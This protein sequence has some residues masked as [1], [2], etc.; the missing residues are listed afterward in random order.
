VVVFHAH[1]GA[2]E[3][4]SVYRAE[5]HMM[6]VVIVSARYSIA[7][8]KEILFP[9]LRDLIYQH[10]LLA[11]NVFT[12]TA[13]KP[14]LRKIDQFD[15]NDIVLFKEHQDLSQFVNNLFDSPRTVIYNDI[16]PAWRLYVLGEHEL[17]FAF[18]HG[19]FD[20]SSGATFHQELL[21]KLQ[22]HCK[23]SDSG[24]IVTCSPDPLPFALEKLTSVKPS[25]LWL[26]KAL[27]DEYWGDHHSSWTGGPP[28]RPFTSK[29]VFFEVAADDV[30]IMLSTA[31]RIG[32]SLTA[33]LYAVHMQAV[34]EHCPAEFLDRDL[35]FT[36]P[37]NA[38][39]YFD[40]HHKFGNYVFS[41][42]HWLRDYRGD[43]QKHH[44]V[45]KW[46]ID[47][48]A[49]LEH[50]LI[51]KQSAY[52]IGALRYVDV[53]AYLLKSVQQSRRAL[54]E[55]SN[56]GAIALDE[57]GPVRISNLA[58]AQACT[59]FGAAF[60][61]NAVSVKNGPLSISVSVAGDDM[62]CS[63]GKKIENSVMSIIQ[64]LQTD[65]GP[66]QPTPVGC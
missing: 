24:S 37:I 40:R 33:V 6:P 25:I 65:E 15:L 5:L 60:T 61:L 55:V 50:E 29:T 4:Y 48:Y 27:W 16:L 28:Q 49:T 30:Q 31:R 36:C 23:F 18:D 34:I 13:S 1:T 66:S 51:D 22:M 41:L 53:K 14:V 26:I 44:F 57:S 58:F 9:A 11:V 45:D 42:D 19:P 43:I 62:D 52:A 12:T 2:L 8:T 63:T 7:L 21:C 38:R 32:V 46:A 35:K 59:S 56:L 39:R 3:A 20:G 54:A 47:F 17:V 10:P 64:S